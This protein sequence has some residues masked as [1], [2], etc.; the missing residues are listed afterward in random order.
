M[1]KCEAKVLCDADIAMLEHLLI[2]E[3]HPLELEQ[4]G[5]RFYIAGV[6]D[7]AEKIIEEIKGGLG[8]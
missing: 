7:M 4:E 3:A 1:L 2:N 6:H 8:E 5:W